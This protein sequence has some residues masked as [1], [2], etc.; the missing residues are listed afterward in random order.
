[1]KCVD[2]LRDSAFN[3]SV[4]AW[5]LCDWEFNDLKKDDEQRQK[6]G[7]KNLGVLQ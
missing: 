7:F 4:T 2:Q 5:H 1:M 3:A 6:L